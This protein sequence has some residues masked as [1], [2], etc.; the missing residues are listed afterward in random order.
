M[1]INGLEI[2]IYR[3]G[4]AIFGVLMVILV[5]SILKVIEIYTQKPRNE[6]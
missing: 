3:L 6:T 2:V 5:F 4:Q 1:E